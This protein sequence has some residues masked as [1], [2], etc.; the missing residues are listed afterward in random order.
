MALPLKFAS[1]HKQQMTAPAFYVVDLYKFQVFAHGEEK[2]RKSAI[3]IY[4]K[5][6]L[7]AFCV[8]IIWDVK[9]LTFYAFSEEK[10][11]S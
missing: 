2:H 4:V 3:K 9:V 6:I 11:L 5:L 1:R 8:V 7:L 10:W